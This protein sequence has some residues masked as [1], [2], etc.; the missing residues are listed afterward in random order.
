ML[1]Y[2]ALADPVR[3]HILDVLRG[4]ERCVSDLVGDL[5][6]SQ[7]SVSKHLKVLRSASLVQVR[8]DG[9]RRWYRLQAEPLEEVAAWLDLYR[10]H[11]EERFDALEQ[12]LEENPT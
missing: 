12:H 7:P 11:W 2:P 4:G 5:Q 3:R 6:V 1:A 10:R 8:R 9:K